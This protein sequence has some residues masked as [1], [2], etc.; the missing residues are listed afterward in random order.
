[1]AFVE[2]ITNGLDTNDKGATTALLNV[3]NATQ[4]SFS[5]AGATG[6]HDDHEIALQLSFDDAKWYPAGKRVTKLGFAQNIPI[7]T[8]SVR[9]RVAREEGSISTVNTIIQAK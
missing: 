8:K 5:V 3:E 7:T 1:M 9:L 6:A 4:V 2:L